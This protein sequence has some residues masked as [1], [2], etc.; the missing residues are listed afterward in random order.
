M[1]EWY[2][3]EK[4][5]SHDCY[6]AFGCWAGWSNTCVR[7]RVESTAMFKKQRRINEFL[8]PGVLPLVRAVFL[9]ALSRS[10]SAARCPSRAASTSA[11][12][13][14]LYL[15]SEVYREGGLRL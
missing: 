12:L 7:P 6:L 2:S 13:R 8:L 5:R 10:S 3:Q 9:R 11:G 4:A 15:C 1:V 14:Q